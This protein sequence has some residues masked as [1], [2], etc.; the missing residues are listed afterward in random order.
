MACERLLERTP[1]CAGPGS[2]LSGELLMQLSPKHLGCDIWGVPVSSCFCLGAMAPSGSLGGN[3]ADRS[4]VHA[5]PRRQARRRRAWEPRV[6]ESSARTLPA[7]AAPAL[8][9]PATQRGSRVAEVRTLYASCPT[10]WIG[11]GSQC[12]YFS[13]DV[14]NWTSSQA[15]C[16]SLDANLARFDSMEELNFLQRHKNSYDHWLG[17]RRQSEQ[18]SWKWA[19]NTEYSNLVKVQ[20]VGQCA[21]LNAVGISSG[22]VYLERRWICSKLSSYAQCGAPASSALSGPS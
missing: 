15:F 2:Q 11:F 22:R 16:E 12:F 5:G 18:H 6:C 1:P 9:R 14:R 10:H 17:L 8:A 21:Y 20:G 4:V 13:D 3:A 7:R 19:D